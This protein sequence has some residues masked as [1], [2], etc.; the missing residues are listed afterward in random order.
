MWEV[1]VTNPFIAVQKE[2]NLSDSE[3]RDRYMS[4]QLLDS[5]AKVL[6]FSYF[7]KEEA[8]DFFKEAVDEGEKKGVFP[9]AEVKKKLKYNKPNERSKKPYFY[10]SVSNKT[11]IRF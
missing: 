3:I 10:A 8:Y 2:L 9:L 4:S 6:P 7:E 11:G 1:L 5:V